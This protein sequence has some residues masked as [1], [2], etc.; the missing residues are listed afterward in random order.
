MQYKYDM[1]GNL[2]YQNSMDAGQRWLLTN[3]LG[4]PLRTW[5]ERNHE[6]QYF[7]DIAQRPTHSKV[8]GGDRKKA[9]GSDDPLDNIFDRVIYG[10]SLLAGI[11]TDANRFNEVALQAKNILGQVI[12]QYDTGGLMDTPDYDFKGQPLATTRKLFK[13]YKEVA[14]WTDANLANDLEPVQDLHLPPKPMP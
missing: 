7:Y 4:K 9:D 12:Q 13:K 11:R 8:I 14:N 3:I 10:E 6:F 1:L 2:V 5:D